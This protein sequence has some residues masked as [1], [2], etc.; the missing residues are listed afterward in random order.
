MTIE[1]RGA[2][3][4]VIGENGVAICSAES[5]EAAVAVRDFLV[6]A[7]QTEQ[8]RQLALATIRAHDNAEKAW[9]DQMKQKRAERREKARRRKEP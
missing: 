8:A 9:R 2:V 7:D 5:L 1:C 3:Y 6:G 4:G